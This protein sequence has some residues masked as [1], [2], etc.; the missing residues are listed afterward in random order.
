MYLKSIDDNGEV[1]TGYIIPEYYNK[2]LA[3]AASEGKNFDVVS[4]DFT[5]VMQIESFRRVFKLERARETDDIWFGEDNDDNGNVINIKFNGNSEVRCQ[6]IKNIDATNKP[7]LA[8]KFDVNYNEPEIY[9]I[10]NCY[11]HIYTSEF[12]SLA[13]YTETIKYTNDANIY[14]PVNTQSSPKTDSPDILYLNINDSDNDIIKICVPDRSTNDISREFAI[15]INPQYSQNKLVELQLTNKSGEK[16]D[17]ISNRREQLFKVPTNM[18]TYLQVNEI[19]HNRFFI[20][21][22]DANENAHDVRTLSTAIRKLSNDLSGEIDYLSTALSGEIDSLSTKLSIE[23]SNEISARLSSFEYLSSQ[24]SSN[25][26]DITEIFKRIKGGV[27]YKG[28]VVC[29]IKSTDSVGENIKD[30]TSV[31]ALFFREG[32]IPASLYDNENK[33]LSNGFMYIVN[34]V[35]STSK[36][37]F[38]IEGKDIEVGDQIIINCKDADGK[39]IKDLTI[40]DV[41]IIDNEDYDTVHQ[42]EF[43]KLSNDLSGEI[44]SLSNALSNDIG[45]LSI[46]LSTEISSLSNNISNDVSYLSVKHLKETEYLSAE[47]SSKIFIDDRI[48]NDVNGHSDLSIVKISKEEYDNLNASDHSLLCANTLYVVEADYIDAYGQVISNLVMTDNTN[49]SE[50]TNKDYVDAIDLRLDTK[51]NTLSDN[52]STEI[53]TLSINL[54]TDLSNISASIEISASDIRRDITTISDDLLSINTRYVNT[55]V[56]SENEHISSDNLILTET[57]HAE[58]DAD[59]QHKQYKMMFERGTIVLKPLN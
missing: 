24:I 30:I 52:L 39:A 38:I 49:P 43:I 41:D 20:K 54:S 31:S 34:A 23:L 16:V 6:I 28:T 29:E 35:D 58:N 37:K 22:L 8:Y 5:N 57:E 21:D 32:T 27:N 33:V 44:D 13:E 55:F 53:S 50:A 14:Y 42:P 40:N 36:K 18:W 25:D 46:N 17:Y 12:I 19:N 2:T 4:V 48:N 26:E 45:A 59:P 10:E 15:V 9:N 3:D 7:T 56:A 11:N 47:I 51:I 1:V